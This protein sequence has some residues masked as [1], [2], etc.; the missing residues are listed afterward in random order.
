LVV[1]HSSHAD[2]NKLSK[3]VIEKTPTTLLG[4]RPSQSQ[5]SDPSTS[6]FATVKQAAAQYP[7]STGAYLREW[8]DPQS[9]QD[10]AALVVSF[11]PSP[12]LASSTNRSAIK[13]YSAAKTLGTT[14]NRASGFTV[15]SVPGAEGAVYTAATP[16]A[17]QA[18]TIYT[19][20]FQYGRAAV[21]EFVD[22]A[23]ST[24]S[25][26]DAVAIAQA[27]YA[28]LHTTEPGFSVTVSKWPWL[29]T[30]LCGV[31][32]LTVAGTVYFVPEWIVRTRTRRAA[33]A[34]FRAQSQYRARG[35]QAVRRH[36]APAWRQ[37]RR[38]R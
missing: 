36:R 13:Q 38:H 12:A 15:P 20:M 14:Y 24:L 28:R 7:A 35:R 2:S 4:K 17:G 30:L 1:V 11:L 22:V 32:T 23:Q 31:I 9:T 33:Q 37:T 26:N 19:V 21:A 8:T 18:N 10:G 6:S 34:Q 27:Q 5:P 25:Q 16:T 3:L 29:A